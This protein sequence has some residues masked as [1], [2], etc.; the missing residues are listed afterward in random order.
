MIYTGGLIR[1]E[2]GQ[3]VPVTVE[4]K[5]P[6]IAD[7]AENLVVTLDDINKLRKWGE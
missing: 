5:P 1:L 4:V 3:I 2:N 7:I 6:T